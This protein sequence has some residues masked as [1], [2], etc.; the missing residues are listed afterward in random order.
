MRRHFLALILVT[1][2]AQPSLWAGPDAPLRLEGDKLIGLPAEYAPAQLDLKA[3]RLQ[4]KNHVMDFT[5]L[6]GGLIGK[7]PGDLSIFASWSQEISTPGRPILPPH[8]VIIRKSEDGSEFDFLFNLETLDLMGISVT[9]LTGG[10]STSMGLAD[11]EMK[12]I[13]A[14]IHEAK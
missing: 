6:L 3:G 10:Q 11:R 1:A 14:S 8:L 12:A 4:I 2:F 9:L 7:T 5:L 13:K